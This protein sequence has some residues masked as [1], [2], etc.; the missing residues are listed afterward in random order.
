MKEIHE[1]LRKLYRVDYS[2]FPTTFST[3]DEA[4]ATYNGL[5]LD[6]K[7]QFKL[8]HV[9]RDIHNQVQTFALWCIN[10]N[11]SKKYYVNTAELEHG[12]DC[13]AHAKFKYERSKGC[14]IRYGTLNL[15][16]DHKPDIKY[17]VLAK[18]SEMH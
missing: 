11:P 1:N 3:P 4:L 17:R 5:G 12:D 18:Q 9:R 14:Y 10:K 7:I 8:H 13:P 2:W 16:H 6:K 15:D